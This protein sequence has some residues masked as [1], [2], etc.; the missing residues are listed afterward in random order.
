MRNLSWTR[1][2]GANYW[3][4]TYDLSL[5]AAGQGKTVFRTNSSNPTDRGRSKSDWTVVQAP[6]APKPTSEPLLSELFQT[7]HLQTQRRLGSTPSPP[8]ASPVMISSWSIVRKFDA[9]II[10]ACAFRVLSSSLALSARLNFTNLR[11]DWDNTGCFFV[12]NGPA[13]F[14]YQGC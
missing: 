2:R 11:E 4:R 8:S 12:G 6:S 7:L 3:K 5:S 9:S 10:F 1:T 13:Q 14:A